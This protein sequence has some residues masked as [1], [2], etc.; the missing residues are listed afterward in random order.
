MGS[1]SSRRGDKILRSTG[2]GLGAVVLGASVLAPLTAVN[3]APTVSQRRPRKP[4]P[5]LEPL[6]RR[7]RRRRL[8]R[9]NGRPATRVAN[10]RPGSPGHARRAQRH[11][12]TVEAVRAVDTRA[13]RYVG[14]RGS[15]GGGARGARACPERANRPAAVL[16]RRRR[17]QRRG[18]LHRDPADDPRW[19]GQERGAG[20]GSIGRQ[21][22][23]GQADRRRFGHDA[24]RH[25]V[26]AGPGPWPVALHP[27]PAVRLR[28]RLGQGDAV[29]AAQRCPV[30]TRGALR[31]AKPGLRAG[32]GR[33][34]APRRRWHDDPQRAVSRPD[35]DGAL[36][37]GKLTADVERRSPARRRERPPRCVGVGAT[38]RPA[39]RGPGRRATSPPST[40]STSTGSGDP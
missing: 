25:G 35:R 8:H 38:L 23:P 40:P 10:V 12:P 11:R 36:L 37:A 39:G 28:P 13:A 33:G 2:R 4:G 14:G 7:G 9:P 34:A 22:R 26:P 20:V 15:C 21:G 27:R 30:P 19:S 17:R 29:R 3:A 32:P 16:H 6:R 31:A 5:R 18:A 1:R 24:G